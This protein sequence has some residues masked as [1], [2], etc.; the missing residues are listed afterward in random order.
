MRILIFEVN[1]RGD[2]LFS[3]PAIRAIRKRYPDSFIAVLVVGRCREILEQNPNIDE[4]IIYEEYQRHKSL[5]GKL[6]LIRELGRKKFDQVFI[7]HRSFTRALMVYL[8][9]I[10]ERIGYN[11]KKRGFLL[12][13]KI[14]LPEQGLHKVEYFLNM[15]QAAGISG[16]RKFYEFYISEGEKAWARQTLSAQGI[17]DND[18]L[19]V[20]NPGGNWKPKRW[21]PDRFAEVG[22]RLVKDYNARVIITGSLRDRALAE[23]IAGLMKAKPISFCGKTDLKKLGA[24]LEKAD[25]V[26]SGDSGPMHIAVALGTRVIALFGPTS[27]AITGPY[28][29]GEYK[30]IWKDVGCEVPCYNFSCNDY[31]CM[32]AITVEDVMQAIK[33]R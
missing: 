3:T 21:F 15:V 24:L 10:P 33:V 23:E 20:L 31:R 8:A 18:F 11:T 19:V 1:W 17:N 7:F 13:K 16:E 25:L 27:P 6:K 30:V 12:T 32:K 29:R 22:D 4:I 26:I 9:G 28:G 5:L 14:E 2:V